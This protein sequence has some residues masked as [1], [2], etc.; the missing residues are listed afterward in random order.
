MLIIFLL[1]TVYV[2]SQVNQ[3]IEVQIWDEGRLIPLQN[4]KVII[5]NNGDSIHVEKNSGFI[6]PDSLIGS[7]KNIIFKVNKLNLS[8]ELM[9]LKWNAENPKWI[10]KID[11]PPLDRQECWYV[12]KRYLKKIKWLYSLDK[13]TGS[14]IT[15]YRFKAPSWR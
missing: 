5:I 12:K 15:E 7:K 13:N 8:F 9:S 6:I 2:Y 11:Y 1:S 14:L 10:I 3:M 4:L